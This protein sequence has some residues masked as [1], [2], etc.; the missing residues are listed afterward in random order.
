MAGNTKQ[1]S[2]QTNPST[3]ATNLDAKRPSDMPDN[4]TSVSSAK[5]KFKTALDELDV[6]RTALV[7]STIENLKPGTAFDHAALRNIQKIETK[8]NRLI[9]GRFAALLKKNEPGVGPIVHQIIEI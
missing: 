3:A 2:K 8:K 5:E 9:V 1:E 7:K 4:S 6:Q